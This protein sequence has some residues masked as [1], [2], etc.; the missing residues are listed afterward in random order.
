[1]KEISLEELKKIQ[2][3]ILDYVDDFCKK[4][5]I[6]YWLDCGT[7]LGAIRHK[8]YIP[9]DD[10]ID[11]GMLRPDY[12]KFIE[13]FNHNNDSDFS[14]ICYENDKDWVFPFGKVLNNNTVFFEPDEKHGI[15]SSVYIDVFPYDNAPEDKKKI[16]RIFK[17]RNLYAKLT[18]LQRFSCFY[19]ERKNKYNFIRYPFHIMMQIFPKDFFVKK[20]VELS[21][22]YMNIQTN[23]VG[24]FTSLSKQ[25]CE[26][27]VFSSFVDVEFEGKKYP[28]PVGYD[29]W[30]KS[31]YGDYMKLP[32]KEKQISHHR[33]EAYY[34]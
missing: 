8:G 29:K 31:F 28:A 21:K 23:L 32:P 3:D 22:K 7:L 18:K 26:K 12:E 1:M 27:D 14:F 11:I 24:N 10:D 13:L 30:L 6:N 16:N 9:W 2:I 4:N 15:K 25:Y 20:G 19:I 5:G 33:Y 34:K 17:K